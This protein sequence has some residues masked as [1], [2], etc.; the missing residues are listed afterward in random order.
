ML[1]DVR[2]YDEF[3]AKLDR[4]VRNRKY[5]L[6]VCGSL[7]III[8]CALGIGYALLTQDSK[9]FTVSGTP[10]R[11]WQPVPVQ[12]PASPPASLG[13]LLHQL[14]DLYTAEYEKLLG[15]HPEAQ[16]VTEALIADRQP[17]DFSIPVGVTDKFIEIVSNATPEENQR[18]PRSSLGYPTCIP[19]QGGRADFVGFHE[20]RVGYL[21]L[22]Q[23]IAPEHWAG[24]QYCVGGE[25]FYFP[26]EMI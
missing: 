5:N 2:D 3:V 8:L 19:Q 14:V 23:Y 6:V 20:Y 11:A 10:V 15:N 22:F 17:S 24:G 21:M 25:F 12:Q 16:R 7:V 9:P 4:T 26:P 18:M 13:Q 1:D